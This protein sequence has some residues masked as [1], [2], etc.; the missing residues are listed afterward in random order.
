MTVFILLPSNRDVIPRLQAGFPQVPFAVVE[1]PA[2][3]IA[4]VG[5]VEALIIPNGQ[6]TPEVAR[7]LKERGRKLKWMQFTT[8]GIDIAI[9]T[10]L[11]DNVI[12]T[13]AAGAN[14]IAVAEHSMA[15][16]L[17]VARGFNHAG[18]ARAEKNWARREMMSQEISPEGRTM[19]IVGLGNIGRDI[20]RKAKA[21]DMRVIGISRGTAPV[22]NVDEIRPR[23]RLRE[24]VA[25]ADVLMLSA[26]YDPSTKG[27]IDRS[28]IASM[29]PNAIFVNTARGQ[30]VDE[31]ALIEAL[32]T[33][34]IAGAGIDVAEIEPPDPA[35]PLWTLPNVVMTPH[36]AGGGGAKIGKLY[37]I[38]ARNL[39]L[40]LAGKPMPAITDLTS[41]E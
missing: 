3:L 21:F 27:M 1:T 24:T 22:P 16:M 13:N 11:P 15:L 14:A 25:E 23:E 17:A 2:E 26:T 8:S 9:K 41:P 12:I 33:G 30:L 28:V 36:S 19:V 4:R 32:Q 40:W 20:A 10:G 18:A 7:A 5:E 6:Y 34:R 35:S 38:I 31:K 29:K 37:E 39:T